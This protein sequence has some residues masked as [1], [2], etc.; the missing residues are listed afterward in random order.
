MNL[1]ELQKKKKKIQQKLKVQ[2]PLENYTPT[3]KSQDKNVSELS[4]ELVCIG[5]IYKDK[6]SN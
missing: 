1:G 5:K 4:L 6:E 2:I 3:P